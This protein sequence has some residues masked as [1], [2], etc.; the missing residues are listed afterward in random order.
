MGNNIL[1][2]IVCENEYGSYRNILER[3]TIYSILTTYVLKD[4]MYLTQLPCVE[5]DSENATF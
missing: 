4:I 2:N 3:T 1:E 5:G